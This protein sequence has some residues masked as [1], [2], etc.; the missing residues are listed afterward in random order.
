[1]KAAVI[2]QTGDPDVIHIEEVPQPTP[3]AEQVLVKVEA[4]SV[5]PIDTYIRAG[6]I[7]MANE[8]PYTIG[9]DFAGVVES[10]GKEVSRFKPG[11]R[12]W[13]SNQSLFGRP[14]S[15]S[16]Y[17]AVDEAWCYPTPEQQSSSE[18]AAGALV[19]ITVHLGLHLHASLQSGEL[20]FVNGGSGGVGS[21][22]IQLAKAQG[23]RVMTT[24]G[25]PRKA[26]F[27]R[28]LGA[29]YVFDYHDEDLDQQIHAIVEQEQGINLWWETLREPTFDRTI[30]FMAKRGRIVLMAGRQAR[31]EFP[32]GPFYVN[33]LKLC[34]FAMFNATAEE[35]REAAEGLNELAGAGMWKPS[36]GVT[37]PLDEAAQAHR[38]QEGKTLTGT[39]DFIGKVV[40]RTETTT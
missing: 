35:Q 19:G 40:L 27:C 38:L 39:E 1:M 33:D 26:D 23:A 29:D 14:G 18:A 4:V 37:L 32:V 10:C 7:A 13:G 9:C 17:L 21:T 28:S 15:F 3:T 12:V 22:V 5:N 30:D 16:E 8:F 20:V 31:P 36:I 25:S 34:G 24:C 2:H 11:D 6:A